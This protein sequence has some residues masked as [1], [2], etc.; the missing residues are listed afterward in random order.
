MVYK[1]YFWHWIK[2]TKYKSIID[3]TCFYPITSVI[4][5][6]GFNLSYKL[7]IENQDKKFLK[8]TF[9]NYISSDLVNQMYENKT[10][11]KLGGEE[12]YHTVIFSDVANFSSISEELSPTEIVEV[13]NEYLTEMTKIILDNG[14][15][16]DKY[17]GDAIVAFYGA[18]I[19][20]KNHENK[21]ILSVLKM[22]DKFKELKDL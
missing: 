18:P 12:G 3:S 6:Y 15:T 21:A 19:E 2:C 1:I 5:S 13:L 20:V 11:P 14:G 4:F 8:S 10:I 22:N 7:Y 9:G 17:I 16:I